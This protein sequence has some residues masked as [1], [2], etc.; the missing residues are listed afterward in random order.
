MRNSVVRALVVT[1]M[2]PTPAR[3]ALGNFVR[4]QVLELRRID[5][6]DVQLHAFGPGPR[7][8]IRAGIDLRRRFAGERF[9]VVHAHFGLT[10][11]P[12]LAVDAGKRVVTLHGNDVYHPRSR[13]VTAAAL[14]R[15]DLIGTPTTG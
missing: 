11:W 12:A 7:S 10:A 2:Y 15:M 4:D 5:D 9:D 1:N 3:P 8:L 14:G 6:L 13:R